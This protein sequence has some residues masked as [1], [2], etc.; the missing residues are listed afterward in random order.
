MRPGGARW[1][2]DCCDWRLCE[3]RSWPRQ[4][5]S[6]SLLWRGIVV[7][8]IVEEKGPSQAAGGLSTEATSHRKHPRLDCRSF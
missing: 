6:A 5:T 7:S 8:L 4:K 2:G 1:G 3:P